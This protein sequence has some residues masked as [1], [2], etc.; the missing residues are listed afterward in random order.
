MHADKLYHEMLERERV[1]AEA[2][3]AGQP[4]PVFKPLL[5]ERSAAEA[6]GQRAA[7]VAS[8]KKPALEIFSAE[9]RQQIEASLANME[10]YRDQIPEG[11]LSN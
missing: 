8:S 1:A 4:E 3:A 11:G 6:L 2:K 7:P 10:K 5:N 9:K